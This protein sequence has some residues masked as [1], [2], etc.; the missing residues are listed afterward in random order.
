MKLYHYLNENR[1]K[2]ITPEKFNELVN[3]NCSDIISFYNKQSKRIFRGLMFN[4]KYVY[5][6]PIQHTRKSANTS[7][8]Y[9]VL[10][11]EILPSWK[12]Y[13]KRS[14]SIICTTNTSKAMGYGTLFKIYP[15]NGSHIGECS[16]GEL[17]K[18]WT[19]IFIP[20]F[21]LNWR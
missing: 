19:N 14:K 21:S 1:S 3:K 8:Y 2:E 13:P 4:G 15:Y 12:N 7:N 11:D 20:Y 9:T 5:V 16:G 18:I 6:N 17:C 10:F